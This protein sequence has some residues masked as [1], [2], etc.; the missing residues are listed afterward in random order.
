MAICDRSRVP[1]AAPRA[2]VA[3]AL[4]T[5]GVSAV[6][7]AYDDALDQELAAAGA[8]VL[9]PWTEPR[10]LLGA[11]VL[12]AG[13]ECLLVISGALPPLAAT[14]VALAASAVL[15]LWPAIRRRWRARS[16]DMEVVKAVDEHDT[17]EMPFPPDAFDPELNASFESDPADDSRP[18]S[19]AALNASAE[20]GSD[21]ELDARSEPSTD[22]GPVASSK[23]DPG[24]ELASSSERGSSHSGALLATKPHDGGSHEHGSSVEKLN[25]DSR[26]HGSSVEKL[27]GAGTKSGP[28]IKIGALHADDV[29]AYAD[30]GLN[31]D[32][33]VDDSALDA[34]TP[35]TPVSNAT[36][37][38]AP[39]DAKAPSHGSALVQAK[40]LTD[41]EE[42]PLAKALVETKALVDVRAL[43][44]A[45]AFGNANFAGPNSDGHAINV[46]AKP[47]S[48]GA[49]P[50]DTDAKAPA[51]LTVTADADSHLGTD[52]DRAAID[53]APADVDRAGPSALAAD[54][55]RAPQR[56]A[57]TTL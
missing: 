22:S 41:D 33:R 55:S 28:V 18:E 51:D 12:F 38:D 40:A 35:A 17:E 37:A 7:D 54:H 45:R 31:V 26:E 15:L 20:P 9:A 50:A 34:K 10:Y 42:P 14:A 27:S 43:V 39:T 21:D 19:D 56:A 30:T 5:D 46:D 1:A 57:R 24:S 53:I 48:D 2:Q 8:G 52:S 11:L 32:I 49:A 25:G 4:T 44:D 13:L 16:A 29:D 36:D 3:Q 6:D 23:P 47:S